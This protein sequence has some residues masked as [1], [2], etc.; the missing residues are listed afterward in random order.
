MIVVKGYRISKGDFTPEGKT[1]AI[2]YHN[3]LLYVDTNEIAE[4]NGV[5]NGMVKVKVDNVRKIGFMK[6]RELLGHE[7]IIGYSI[8]RDKPEVSSITK[9]STEPVECIPVFNDA[10]EAE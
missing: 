1:E 2:K 8:G 4:V 6:W 7:I 10:E 9:V 5:A 3:A